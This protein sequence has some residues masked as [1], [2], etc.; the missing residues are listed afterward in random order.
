MWVN[1]NQR[2][3]YHHPKQY[4]DW[5]LED[6]IYNIVWFEGQQLPDTL[7]S[8]ESDT[9]SNVVDSNDGFVPSSEDEAGDL[10]SDEI[11]E[12]AE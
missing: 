5:E 6:D 4:D 12:D 10:G 8:D 1:A 9:A 3:I 2:E 7:V 11:I